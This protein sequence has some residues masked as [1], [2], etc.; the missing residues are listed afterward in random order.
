MR[1]KEQPVG[2][3]KIPQ[4]MRVRPHCNSKP[5]E[6]CALWA[7]LGFHVIFQHVQILCFND[8]PFSKDAFLHE[9]D[10]V[11]FKASSAHELM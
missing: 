7:N 3:T 4:L 11:L 6:V 10:R 5:A 9:R 8:M 1:K 2:V